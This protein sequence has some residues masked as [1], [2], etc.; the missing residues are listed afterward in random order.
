MRHLAVD[1]Q[2]KFS[3]FSIAEILALPG[4]YISEKNYILTFSCS[5][6][7]CATLICA[8][9]INYFF[10]SR[11]NF[12]TNYFVGTLEILTFEEW[13]KNWPAM[14][15][16]LAGMRWE[17]YRGNVQYRAGDYS[18]QPA[19]FL[20]R[21]CIIQEILRMEN[22][23]ALAFGMSDGFHF[24]CMTNRNKTA[25]VKEEWVNHKANII[26]LVDRV[27]T[28]FIYRVHVLLQIDTNIYNYIWR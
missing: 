4:L 8:S 20:A 24:L 22:I 21:T 18:D 28:I 5:K 16:A 25:R 9:L 6:F 7:Y 1:F 10:K 13:L 12:I 11:N 3:L 26:L 17:F 23:L 14:N 27:I 15:R 19:V 2:A